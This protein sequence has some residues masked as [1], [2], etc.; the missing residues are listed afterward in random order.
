M[1]RQPL[2]ANSQT[3]GDYL[4]IGSSLGGLVGAALSKRYDGNNDSLGNGNRYT[5]DSANGGAF[6][7]K[8]I[9][10]LK[11]FVNGGLDLSKAYG[12]LANQKFTVNGTQYTADR[13]G[14]L[15]TV[16]PANE[17]PTSIG[18]GVSSDIP[19]GFAKVLGQDTSNNSI[20]LGADGKPWQF[21]PNG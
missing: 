5:N 7:D 2:N 6:N 18:M 16:A 17:Q 15:S 4:N 20:G 10:D 8:Q 9:K 11:Q 12:S 13:N 21:K 14:L 19:T 1:A 3:N